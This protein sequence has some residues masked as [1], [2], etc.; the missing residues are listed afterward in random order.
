MKGGRREI[1]AEIGPDNDQPIRV[2]VR[3]LPQQ[4]GIDEAERRSRAPDAH[5]DGGAGRECQSW[6]SRRKADAVT[7]ILDEIVLKSATLKRQR[8]PARSEAV[9]HQEPERLMP[10]SPM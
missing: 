4:R 3:P 2:R 8:V 7:Y 9:A 6:R 10:L 5:R 1:L